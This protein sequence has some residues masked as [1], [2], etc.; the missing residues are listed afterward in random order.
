GQ[1]ASRWQG[2]HARAAKPPGK[3]LRSR[4]MHPR[5][6]G[7]LSAG[8]AAVL[9]ICAG[10]GGCAA[11]PH[12]GVLAGGDPAGRA[13]T[14]QA[15]A[16]GQPPTAGTAPAGGAFTRVRA[17]APV[18]QPRSEVIW[19][20]DDGRPEKGMRGQG[21]VAPDGTLILGPYGLVRVAGM[22]VDQARGAIE[23][24]V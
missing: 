6:K 14:A 2:C 8:L 17:T 15:T 22:T 5:C 24:H 7:R 4:D 19:S 20:I 13:G 16:A 18:L 23:R 12:G 1:S 3:E 10:G 9:A 11:V 21:T